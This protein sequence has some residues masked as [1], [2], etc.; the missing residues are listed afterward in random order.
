MFEE[1]IRGWIHQ[2]MNLVNQKYKETIS[3]YQKDYHFANCFMQ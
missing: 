3:I 1:K 2:G